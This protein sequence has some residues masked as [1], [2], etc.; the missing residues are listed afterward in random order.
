MQERGRI[1]P[2]A[3]TKVATAQEIIVW[4]ADAKTLWDWLCWS[5]K[6][7]LNEQI[8]RLSMGILR[9]KTCKTLQWFPSSRRSLFTAQNCFWTITDKCRLIPPSP[10]LLLL[11]PLLLLR[12]ANLQLEGDCVVVLLFFC[13]IWVV[14]GGGNFRDFFQYNGD[15]NLNRPHCG[16]YR[17]DC[18]FSGKHSHERCRQL[19]LWIVYSAPLYSAERDVEF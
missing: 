3:R 4:A 16:Q 6:I 18:F 12:I 14:V 5:P 8:Q 13:F 10:P 17:T 7:K 9:V 19:I 2:S 1:W 11:L 15:A